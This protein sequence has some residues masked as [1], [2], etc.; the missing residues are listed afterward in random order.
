MS[1]K[2]Q[3]RYKVVD[4][5]CADCAAKL[6]RKIAG[7]EGLNDVTL[8]FMNSTLL[9]TCEEEQEEE[10]C[11]KIKAVIDK[12][13]PDAKLLPYS[14]K[15]Q[16]SHSHDHH[17]VHTYK[18][19]VEDIDCADC[20]AKLE[21]KIARI[22]GLANVSLNFMTSTLQ[23]DCEPGKEAELREQVKAVIAKEEPD[24][25]FLENTGTSCHVHNHEHHDHHHVHT[26]K[27]K[28]EDI[29]CADCAA[30]LER[31]I[32]EIDGLE[33]VTLNF[34]TSTLQYDCEPGRESELRE[35]VKAVIAKEEPDAKF[36]ENSGTSCH[37]HHH[38]H[39]HH[40]VHTYKYKVE[41]IDCADCAAKLE[42]KI[43]E[44]DGLENVTLNFMTST[45]QY[46]C[47]P[48]KEEG[49]REQVKA[50]IADEEPDAKFIDSQS[51]EKEIVAEEKAFE[52][53]NAKEDSEQ[54]IMLM[55]LG[56]G[57]VLFAVAMF[58]EGTV[59]LGIALVAYLILGYD[60][61]L[62][63][64]RGIGRGQLFDEHFLMTIAT[65]AAIYLGDM[66]EAC[67]VMLFYQIGEFFQDLAVSRSRRSIASLMDIRPEFAMVKH[68][69]TWIKE[70]PEEVEVGEIIQVRPGE[71][72]PL[73][74]TVIY[75]AS[76]LDTSSLTGES[77]PMDADVGT[78]VISGSIN[79]T[80]VLEIRVDKA[81]GE[82]T[83]ARILDLV[84]NSSSH[85]AKAENFITSFSR[86]YTPIVVFSAI[87]VACFVGFFGEGWNEGIYRACTFLV[88]SCPCALVISVPLSFF[89]GIGGLSERGVLVKGANLI[90][91]LAKVKHVVMDKTGTLT[92]GKFA[93]EEMYGEDKEAL[94]RDAAYAESY[95]SHPI[96]VGIREAYEKDIDSTKVTD[97][98][99][100][101]GRGLSCKIDGE[102]VLAGNAKLLKENN[103]D[104]EE[105]KDAGT[106]VY[107]AR[108]GKY[109]GCLVLRDQ[110]KA[111]AVDAVKGLQA[112][113]CTVTI[114]SGDAKEIT[115][116]I[117]K[118]TGADR[119]IGQCLPEDKV[120]HVNE[121][122]NSGVTAFVGDGVNDAPVLTVADTGIAMG[123]LGSDAAIEAADV[124]IM[125]DSPSKVSLAISGASRILKVAN[126][127]IW[128][129]IIIK[130]AT[131]ILGAFG[132]A[133]MWM[134][135]FA[136]TG[137]AMLCVLNSLRLLKV[138]QK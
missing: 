111:D 126:Q 81:Y 76:S 13:E 59:S 112:A 7:I 107:V 15:H 100:I 39:D 109:E 20:A 97:M 87:A 32:A 9:F 66:K 129:A 33:N 95:S 86:W 83:V 121:I 16:H 102:V 12:E 24:A 131:L 30:K 101:A 62:K 51:V 94:L 10:M 22:D 50:V 27:Y 120:S 67:G 122:K 68:G 99:E 119:V 54:K 123:A 98:Q 47:E 134:A 52:D 125:D 19:K 110:L 133:N 4:I 26:Y 18:Y 128:F 5:D 64:F 106:L 41:D 44:I 17:H 43:A 28:V 2:K 53:E 127:N 31:K 37:V 85:K 104:F 21:R 118:K 124:V 93:V 113:G 137:V 36:L 84:E 70:D 105:C 23:Y 136:D 72:V 58:L 8:N 40:H 65:F 46:D 135:I 71:R 63:A 49:L 73:D 6:E 11:E 89:A 77:K 57:A 45:L 116:D 69:E 114:L 48:G 25:K 61:I 103:I 90:E 117:G 79:Q 132:I 82:S 130:V 34:M 35:Q 56:A 108:N 42:R 92:S 3:C 78:Q 138:K 38:E 74:G 55:R 88:I 14:T 80:G 60:V 115:E 96:A 1:N 29:D 91:T 75:G